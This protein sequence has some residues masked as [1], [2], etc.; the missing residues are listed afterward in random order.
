MRTVVGLIGALFVSL[1][2]I[3]CSEIPDDRPP[4]FPVTGTVTYKGKPVADALVTFA[5][6]KSPRSANA[7]TNRDGKYS[8]T[9]FN[10]KDGAVAGEHLVVIIKLVSQPS[11]S[12]PAM[13]TAPDLSKGLPAGYPTADKTGKVNLSSGGSENQLPAKYADGKLPS[14]KATVSATGNNEF[15]FDLED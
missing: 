6:A 2:V 3:G 9:T 1:C 11:A 5:S 12:D 7:T 4:V 14:M 10:S 15:N 8:L 13:A